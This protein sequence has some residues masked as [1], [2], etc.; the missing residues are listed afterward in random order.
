MKHGNRHFLSSAK[1]FTH[2]KSSTVPEG[3]WNLEN[4]RTTA[5]VQLVRDQIN[6]QRMAKLKGA[7]LLTKP[8][9]LLMRAQVLSVIAIFRK[10][11]AAAT[12]LGSTPG[13][14]DTDFSGKKVTAVLTVN[15]HSGL[16]AQAIEEAFAK[17]G[18]SV[19]AT[20]R[21][22]MQSVVD[23]V[24]DKTT[25]L[26][27]GQRAS[28]V[29][30]HVMRT[31]VNE[32][33]TKVTQINN[34]TKNNLSKLIGK[35]IDEGTP[36]FAVMELVRDKIPGIAT[37]RVPTIV[38]TEMGLAADRASIR[39]MKDSAVVTHVS[40]T[41]CEAIEKGIPTWNGIPTCNIR[42]VPIEYSG[43][44]QFHP[45]HT[46]AIIAS[47]FRKRDG[48]VQA[49]PTQQGAGG[50]GTWEDRGR[51][52]PALVADVPTTP[53][54]PSTPPA[55]PKPPKPPTPPST[56]PKP[57]TSP[58]KPSP[59]PVTPP[60]PPQPP[61]PVPVPVRAPAPPY[62]RQP[63][64]P[65]ISLPL[66]VE[67]YVSVGRVR[68]LTFNLSDEELA[69]FVRVSDDLED[70]GYLLRRDAPLGPD[71]LSAIDK[72]DKV[73]DALV[74]N[75]GMT[76][77]HG[78][79]L[80]DD[81][82]SL[83]DGQESWVDKSP[84]LASLTEEGRALNMSQLLQQNL[85][86]SELLEVDLEVNGVFMPLWKINGFDQNKMEAL[87]PRGSHYAVVSRTQSKVVLKVTTP[88][89]KIIP[90]EIPKEVVVAIPNQVNIPAI[91]RRKTG[92]IQSDFAVP[93]TFKEVEAFSTSLQ[94][95][96]IRLDIEIDKYGESVAFGFNTSSLS[97][98]KLKLYVEAITDMK[99]RIGMSPQEFHAHV[100]AKTTAKDVKSTTATFFF[101]K[102]KQ[103]KYDA[104][105]IH[106]NG[107]QATL[108]RQFRGGAN[109]GMAVHHD[110]FKIHERYQG[111]GL[112]KQVSS[113]V[114]SMYDHLD[115]RLIDMNANIDVGGYAWARYGF[116][117]SSKG[118]WNNMLYNASSRMSRLKAGSTNMESIVT[119][120]GAKELAEIE[121][122]IELMKA[123]LDVKDVRALSGLRQPLK[124]RVYK[125][126]LDGNLEY[127]AGGDHILIEVD[128][129]VGK[130]ILLGTSWDSLIDLMDGESY[131][132]YRK[133]ID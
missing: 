8:L 32:I 25:T 98:N 21:P 81:F 53:K 40:V 44:L 1:L 80:R 115:V 17:E 15:Q 88:G 50:I 48:G 59:S 78:V 121:E 36:P 92:H 95:A 109:G 99:E 86:P 22:A 120:L 31:Q 7:R 123:Q 124:K 91:P 89:I 26:L 54:P 47:V 33:A 37:N 131:S 4:F 110:Y 132:T 126:D 125:K 106:P 18:A 96:G 23:D 65:R 102:G 72:T 101:E 103:F 11:Y 58:P 14:R 3:G 82:D 127:D 13:Q 104:K 42:N 84:M 35:A 62:V 93:T 43:E 24:L 97:K 69:A 41:G 119:Q 10:K 19:T 68:T 108:T 16:W 111:T 100:F 118:E 71:Y 28:E 113:Q 73:F 77:F 133:Y 55:P 60:E 70:V 34:T 116:L 83:F 76:K 2:Y 45:N 49:T 85:V 9:T 90:P 5:G 39:A 57:P 20:V 129:T 51:P 64:T 61:V 63:A 75:V 52:V 46:G 112:A 30:R 79:V 128:T 87:I 29:S 117:P 6:V 107:R 66:S 67:G 27:T 94:A 38:R 74:P 122:T 130:E 114:L 105:V 56:P 12:G